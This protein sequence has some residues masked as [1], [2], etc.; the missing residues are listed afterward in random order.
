[1]NLPNQ[2]TM[3]RLASLPV[4]MLF[5]FIDTVPA[6]VG[7]F[8]I[9]IAA[10]ITD[11][12]DGYIARKRNQITPLGIFLDPLADKLIITAAFI[13]LVEIHD[14]H[15]PAWMVVF[16]VGREF[17][18][19]GL[20]AVAAS[21]GQLLA[22]DDG[23]KFKTAVQNAVIITILGRLIV[24]TALEQRYGLTLDSLFQRG[25]WAAEAARLLDWTPYWLVF[26]ATLVSLITGVSYLRKHWSL[27]K[28][29]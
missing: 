2:L 26:G 25:G 29:N 20:R 21:R 18:L 22:A 12:V 27:L 23:G 1:M 13:A 16:I 28:E 10:G 7:A 11:L 8:V 24:T 5:M 9:F 6:R 17:V 4:F 14:L 19:T 3:A 15:I